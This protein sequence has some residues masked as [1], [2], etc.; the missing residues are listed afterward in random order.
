MTAAQQVRVGQ[1]MDGRAEQVD[2]VMLGSR[3]IVAWPLMQ[4]QQTTTL[5]EI[6]FNL[7]AGVFKR[8]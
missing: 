1:L 2:T 8:L 5:E 7:D 3:K 4:E 6:R